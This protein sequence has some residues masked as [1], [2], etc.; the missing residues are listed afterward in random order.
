MSKR[1]SYLSL[2]LPEQP[3]EALPKVGTIQTVLQYIIK[4]E[5]L[6]DT[7]ISFQGDEN[8]LKVGSGNECT[9]VNTLK[10]TKL[11]TSKGGI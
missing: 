7:G 10:L 6:M 9:T 3:P 8:V 2:H 11:Y 5:L 4:T 1:L